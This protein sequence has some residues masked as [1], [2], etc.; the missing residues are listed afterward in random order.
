MA[1]WA[2]KR[3]VRRH[4]QGGAL[5]P[6][7]QPG[8][9]RRLAG[10]GRAEQHDVLLTG[11]DPPLELV[12]GLRLVA[13]RNEVGDHLEGGDGSG[14][15]TGWAHT[16]TLAP[17]TDRR[18]LSGELAPQPADLSRQ[19][20]LAPTVVQHPIGQGE[21]LLPGRLTRHPRRIWASLEPPPTESLPT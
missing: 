3:L 11:A 16:A 7:D 9:G 6:L 10:A 13:A 4:D 1:S 5:Q 18:I 14:D 15:V 20:L 19:F 8:G 12:D 2:A 21:P 17:G